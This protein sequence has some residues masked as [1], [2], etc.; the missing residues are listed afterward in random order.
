MHDLEG[1]SCDIVHLPLD[2]RELFL[3]AEEAEEAR[4]E[5]N[6]NDCEG[7]P[8]DYSLFDSPLSSPT[9]SPTPSRASSPF[10]ALIHSP[11]VYCQKLPSSD[12]CV[13]STSQNMRIRTAQKAH[14]QAGRKKRRARKRE[15]AKLTA[16]PGKYKIRATRAEACVQGKISTVKVKFDAQALHASKPGFIGRT[17]PVKRVHHNLQHYRGLGF[18]TLEWNGKYVYRSF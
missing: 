16:G 12:T 14:A 17:I 4:H 2:V 15:E 9:P 11:P 13:S 1:S 10:P 6:G 3:M 7:H 8:L 5:G 18:E